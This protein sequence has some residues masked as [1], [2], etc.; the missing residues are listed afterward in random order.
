MAT[1]LRTRSR[2]FKIPTVYEF[3][4]MLPVTRAFLRLVLG[5]S[6]KIRILISSLADPALWICQFASAACWV[7]RHYWSFAP[8]TLVGFQPHSSTVWLPGSGEASFIKFWETW[9]SGS[10]DR[11]DSRTC[12]LFHGSQ[13]CP[14]QK[15]FKWSVA[16]IKLF[17]RS[18]LLNVRCSFWANICLGPFNAVAHEAFLY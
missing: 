13:I 6:F 10:F 8:S 11:R 5:L 4:L 14:C 1:I 9:W 12:S 15:I 2:I 3:I 17:L 16:H 7:S 18:M